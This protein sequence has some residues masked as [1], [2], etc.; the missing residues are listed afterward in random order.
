VLEGIG[1][2]NEHLANHPEPRARFRAF[3]T[4]SLDFEL[5]AWIT[6]PSMRGLRIHEINCA[7]NRRFIEENIV[8]PFPQQ[9]VWIK[10]IPKQ[11][12]T[13]GS[14]SPQDSNQEE[15]DQKH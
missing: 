8:I 3:G 12:S 13:Q 10:E 1:K 14:Q 7:I 2:D 15:P 5:L 6:E 4:S 11:N 9:D